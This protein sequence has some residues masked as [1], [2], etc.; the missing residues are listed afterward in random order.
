MYYKLKDRIKLNEMWL[1]GCIE[2]VADNVKAPE[3]SFVLGWPTENFVASFRC[4]S[5][6]FIQD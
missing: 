5:S 4:D 6:S 1:S 2:D 3:K